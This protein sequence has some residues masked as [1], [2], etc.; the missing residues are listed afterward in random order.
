MTA[1]RLSRDPAAPVSAI[2]AA[3]TAAPQ[4]TRRASLM[5]RAMSR[6]SAGRP[7][8]MMADGGMQCTVEPG[9]A[10]PRLDVH[11][12]VEEPDARLD[13]AMVAQRVVNGLLVG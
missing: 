6:G 8:P 1:A 13:I 4:P 9:G 12:E 5:A 3:T 7:P 11:G 10:V 2:A